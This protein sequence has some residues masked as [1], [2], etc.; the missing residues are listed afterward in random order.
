VQC[1]AAAAAAAAIS[2]TSVHFVASSHIKFII[3]SKWLI[4]SKL[5]FKH[6]KLSSSS[7]SCYQV[8]HQVHDQ[9][10]YYLPM[11]FK[12]IIKNSLFTNFVQNSSSKILYYRMFFK[13]IIKVFKFTNVFQIHHQNL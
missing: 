12:F 9:I 4:A 11:F 1:A 10:L 8:H 5:F 7:N 6:K 3:K 2:L 13:F